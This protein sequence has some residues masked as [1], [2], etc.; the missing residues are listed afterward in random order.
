[1][2][3][4]VRFDGSMLHYLLSREFG[5]VVCDKRARRMTVDY[6]VLYED[7]VDMRGHAVLASNHV[8]HFDGF[9]LGGAVLVCSGDDVAAAARSEDIPV[10]QVNGNVPFSRL[11]NF[12]LATFMRFE[13]LDARLHT[14]VSAREG[15]RA[16]LDAC[17]LETGCPFA[18]VDEQYC[19]IYE[20]ALGDVHP[21]LLADENIDLF[22]A[23]HRYRTMRA[24]KSVSAIPGS[25][26]LLMKNLFARKRLRGTLI[27]RH[28]GNALGARFVRFFLNYLSGFLED[29]YALMGSF[30]DDLVE[31][32]QMRAAMSHLLSGGSEN[33]PEIESLLREGGLGTDSSYAILRIERSFTHEGAEELEY[34]SRRLEMSWPRAHCFTAEGALFMFADVMPN[35]AS[36]ERDFM[37]DILVV[38]RDNLAKVGMSRPFTRMDHLDAARAQATA[39]LV[40]GSLADP[41]FW[42]YRFDDYALSWLVAHGKGDVPARHIAHPA[43]DALMQYDEEH[44]SE[45]LHTLSVFVS[46]RYNATKASDELYVARSTLLNRLE[47][48]HELTGIDLD[49]PDERLYLALSFAMLD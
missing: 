4:A 28:E 49:D 14:C 42:V 12:L 3:V 13:R 38:A 10:I 44:D 41:S 5:A 23:S 17:T 1:M 34:L 24:S 25:G 8:R 47:R 45:L 29:T 20:S 37:K 16:I 19:L 35:G 40:Q 22:M 48:V 6:P 36:A 7:G 39:A 18:L 21:D 33:A 9:H 32:D 11:C 31:S 2:G 30:G 26:E 43:V 27:S 46:C 15:A